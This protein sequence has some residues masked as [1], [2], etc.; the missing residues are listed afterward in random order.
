MKVIK[1][2][3]YDWRKET[4]YRGHNI[5]L[6][7]LMIVVVSINKNNC[8]SLCKLLSDNNI[9]LFRLLY[10]N[11]PLLEKNKYDRKRFVTHTCNYKISFKQSNF[12]LL[13]TTPNKY[14]C[15][16]RDT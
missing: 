4:E 8:L 9:Y 12:I 1:R 2:Y 13:K 3:T 11:N 14:M 15:E 16:Y 10:N 6:N 7:F 5:T